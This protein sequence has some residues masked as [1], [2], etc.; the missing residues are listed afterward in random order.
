MS[1]L[2]LLFLWLEA[3]KSVVVWLYATLLCSLAADGFVLR[4][5][6]SGLVE[7]LAMVRVVFSV[8]LW[9]VSLATL[10]AACFAAAFAASFAAKLAAAF[11]IPLPSGRMMGLEAVPTTLKGTSFGIFFNPR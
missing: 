5:R 2:S 1:P 3:A 11:A 7:A 9:T 4:V 8:N 10:L 6:N